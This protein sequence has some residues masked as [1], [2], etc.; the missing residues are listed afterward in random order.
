MIHPKVN[1][2]WSVSWLTTFATL[3]HAIQVVSPGLGRRRCQQVF[4]GAP[5]AA[6]E[7]GVA[8]ASPWL[9][10]VPCKMERS[11]AIWGLCWRFVLWSC[12][13]IFSQDF[14]KRSCM[15]IFSRDQKCPANTHSDINLQSDSKTWTYTCICTH[16]CIDAF[17]YAH[18][19]RAPEQHRPAKSDKPVAFQLW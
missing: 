7:L 13:N 19:N 10:M 4:W 15:E 6:P 2:H 11:I 17:A 3:A 9:L 18:E 14:L 1:I 8:S 5:N 12:P 16:K